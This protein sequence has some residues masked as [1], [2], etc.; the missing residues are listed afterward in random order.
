MNKRFGTRAHIIPEQG[1][2]DNKI[3][4][5]RFTYEKV[6][7]KKWDEKNNRGRRKE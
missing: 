2:P 3:G 4:L 7:E 1:T 6:T 5:I